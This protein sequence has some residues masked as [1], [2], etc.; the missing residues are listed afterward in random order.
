[1]YHLSDELSVSV[2]AAAAAAEAVNERRAC[3]Q[4]YRTMMYVTGLLGRSFSK[5][6]L[7]LRL[8][9]RFWFSYKGN[10]T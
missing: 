10:R 6:V 3:L 2:A 1:M 8:F 7:A 9:I 4:S 5:L